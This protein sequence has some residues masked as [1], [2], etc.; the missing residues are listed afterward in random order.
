MNQPG[1]PRSARRRLRRGLLVVASCLLISPLVAAESASLEA[2]V[3]AKGPAATASDYRRLGEAY[4]GERNLAQAAAAFGEALRK[5]EADQALQQQ[6]AALWEASGRPDEAALIWLALARSD[7]DAQRAG[8]AWLRAAELI[9]RQVGDPRRAVAEYIA[10]IE[11]HPGTPAA[12]SACQRGNQAAGQHRLDRERRRIADLAIQQ[13]TQDAALITEVV[14]P[15]LVAIADSDS[16]RALAAIEVMRKAQPDFDASLTRVTLFAEVLVRAQRGA[17]GLAALDALAKAGN[18]EASLQAGIFARQRLRDEALARD[19]L[20]AFLKADPTHERGAEA[21]REYKAAKGDV[22]AFAAQAKI[23][24]GRDALQKRWNAELRKMHDAFHRSRRGEAEAKALWDAYQAIDLDLA[25]WPRDPL[26]NRNQVAARLGLREAYIAGLT[27]QIRRSPDLA[28]HGISGDH[29]LPGDWLD[30]ALALARKNL[31]SDYER[32]RLEAWQIR[33]GAGGDV[34]AFSAAVEAFVTTWNAQPRWCEQVLVDRLEAATKAGHVQTQAWLLALVDRIDERGLHDHRSRF[35]QVTRAA[36]TDRLA[37]LDSQRADQILARINRSAWHD[38]N[39][40]WAGTTLVER[41]R[42]RGDVIGAAITWQTVL[43]RCDPR[44]RDQFDLLFASAQVEV[45]AGRHGVAAGAFTR[46]HD[47]FTGVD[48]ERRGKAQRQAAQSAGQIGGVVASSVLAIDDKDPLAPILRA[49]A[50][51]AAG[52]EAEA[53]RLARPAL[54]VLEDGIDRVSADL[55]LL[56]A[57]N[58]AREGEADTGTA[59]V[60]SLLRQNPGKDATVQAQMALGDLRYAAADYPTALLDF[61]SVIASYGDRDEARQAELRVA[62]CHQAMRQVDEARRL[63][64]RLSEDPAERIRVQA[65]FRLALLDQAEGQGEAAL[66][67]FRQLADLRLPEDLAS[68]LYLDWGKTLIDHNRLREAEDVILMVGIQQARDP[69]A[70]GETLRVTL[71]DPFLQAARNRNA[72]PVVVS[73]ASGDQERIE[74]TVS[75]DVK[76]LYTGAMPTALGSTRRGDGLLQVRGDDRITYDYASDFSVEGRREALGSGDIPIASQGE[77]KVGASV[78]SVRFDGDDSDG[79]DGLQRLGFAVDEEELERE[80]QLARSAS[81]NFRG[82]GRIRP[83]GSVHVSVHDA[84]RDLSPERDRV[85]VLL[86]SA[87]GDQVQAELV[88][89]AEHSGVFRAEVASALMPATIRCSDVAVGGS[90]GSLLAQPG[91]PG[92]DRADAA[93]IGLGNRQDGKTI[94]LDFRQPTAVDRFLWSR[95]DNRASPAKASAVRPGLAA[96]YFAGRNANGSVRHVEHGL[97][98]YRNLSPAGLGNDNWSVRYEGELKIAK[99]GTYRFR[100]RVDDGLRLIIAGRD[101]FA[102]KEWRDSGPRDI[103]A[104][105]ELEAGWTPIII[106]AYQAT[107]GNELAISWGIDAKDVKPAALGEAD[108]RAKVRDL[109]PAPGRVPTVWR[110]ETSSDGRWWTPLANERGPLRAR[111]SLRTA[112]MPTAKPPRK[113]QEARPLLDQVL[114]ERGL[115]GMKPVA[116]GSTLEA[117]AS[118]GE[119][120]LLHRAW[121]QLLVPQAGRYEFAL[122]CGGRGWLLVG[123]TIVVDKDRDEA[124]RADSEAVWRGSIELPA[125]LVPIALAQIS[126]NGLSGASILWMPSGT[127]TFAPL[128][129]VLLS[130]SAEDAALDAAGVPAAGSMSSL[131]DRLGADIRFR[132]R[133]VRYLR[134]VIDTWDDGDAPAVARVA[135]WSGTDI[136]VPAADVDYAALGRNET[137]ELAAGDVIEATY[138]DLKTKTRQT[139]QRRGELQAVWFDGLI[140]FLDVQSHVDAQ[141]NVREQ[142]FERFRF[143]SGDRLTARVVDYDADLSDQVDRIAVTFT[144]SSGSVTVEGVETGEATG[145]FHAELRTGA[146]AGDGSKAML[147]VTDGEMVSASYDDADNNVPGFRFSRSASVRET[148]ASTGSVRIWPTRRDEAGRIVAGEAPVSEAKVEHAPLRILIAD[149]DAQISAGSRILLRLS[150]EAGFSSLVSVV[151]GGRSSEGFLC[152]IPLVLGGP[153]TG[154]WTLLEPGQP[155]A[156]NAQI[157]DAEAPRGAVPILALRGGDT[158]RVEYLE[159]LPIE[160]DAEAVQAALAQP[161]LPSAR[162]RLLTSG[163]LEALGEDGETAV[164]ATWVGGKVLIR[165]GDADADTSAGRDLARVTVR[166]GLGDQLALDLEET[167]DDSGVFQA[168]LAIRH[169]P[170]AN[171]GD[172][173]LQAG[174]GDTVTVTYSGDGDEKTVTLEVARGHD[175]N[176]LGFAKRFADE[177]FAA[178]TQIRLA[179]CSFELYKQHRTQLKELEQADGDADER[180]RLEDLIA[181]E[182]QEGTALLRRTIHDYPDSARLDEVLFLLGNF[183]QEGGREREAIDR[184]R[185]LLAAFAESPRAVEAQYKLAQCYEALERHDEAWEAYVRLAYRWSDH[186]LVGDSMARIGDYYE[187]RGKALLAEAQAQQQGKTGDGVPGPAREDL[188]QAAKVYGQLV[189]RFPEHEHAQPIALKAAN[190]YWLVEDY[191]QARARFEGFLTT[192]EDS[193]FRDMGLYWA[194]RSA[195][196]AG[197]AKG[198]ALHLYTLIQNHPESQEAKR[199][200]GLLLQDSRLS[201]LDFTGE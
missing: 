101:L 47:Y 117:A 168:G 18:V 74:L 57:R 201:Q 45:S 119:Q 198:A 189:K 157:V 164:T 99:A 30:E 159:D 72:V 147:A 172:S 33:R 145:I 49:Q 185:T 17:D 139:E 108:L 28:V 78:E 105:V 118:E 94:T 76:G 194:G 39:G 31:D 138:V 64:E 113:V 182:L 66:A 151:A 87:S 26:N 123:D 197:D 163:H 82:T 63:Y 165:L 90:L 126:E 56:V 167:A 169:A 187:K 103:Q 136:L 34:D 2:E 71:R 129:E 35:A 81:R 122:R 19:R 38:T 48:E 112:A 110:A 153:E 104:T 92:Y 188:L 173:D 91:D 166:S 199:A 22:S 109:G 10:L 29:G 143:R 12:R 132:E 77:L 13:F 55:V 106:E 93:W 114:S 50:Q 69:I 184:Y 152:E 181:Q 192:Y 200:R 89:T 98:A 61:Q 154:T 41:L 7:Q 100:A 62:D 84:D 156:Q 191:A 196:E 158:L 144:A 15:H 120:P 32:S 54:K 24:A 36:L 95:G 88:E 195:L 59:L 8:K 68:Q 44:N 37:S 80:R 160:A 149:P 142:N 133:K 190:C 155:K 14:A 146:D 9:E 128:P 140:S 150:T 83:G 124:D 127:E 115:D 174:F 75:P 193:D 40:T 137:L 4:V 176:I 130:P 20:A 23:H 58:L 97:P 107:G 51:L 85:S 53:Y 171:P 79:E 102:G 46:L 67:R 175:A 135:A 177:A 186:S 25:A 42:E 162:A 52:D 170:T 6:T 178:S 183:E 121:G 134:M 125:G 27:A 179:E 60:K 148:V 5:G 3:R 116:C 180:K 70:P 65:I 1:S 73:T 96:T 86:Q 131:E 21:L 43:T 16:A 111:G 11:A 141:G 161:N